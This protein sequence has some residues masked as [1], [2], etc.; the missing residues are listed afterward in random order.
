MRKPAIILILVLG[1]CTTTPS[2]TTSTAA[3]ATT[4]TP[5]TT[6]LPRATTDEMLER[7]GGEPCSDSDFTCV[8]I[9]VPL[10]HSQ[11]V[12]TTEVTFAVLA[13]RGERVGTLVMATGGPG[14]DG[15]TYADSYSSVLDEAI[16]ESF[17][18]VFYDQRGAGLSGGVDCPEASVAYYQT[19]ALTG[20]GFDTEAL[21]EAART[22]VEDCLAETRGAHLLPY[23][24]T[25]QVVGDIE[26]F[27]EMM[28]W[29]KL[30]I[31]GESYGTQVA[32][33]YAAAYP[34]RVER[35]VIDGVVDLTLEGH[36]FYRQWTVAGS[37]TLEATFAACGEDAICSSVLPDPGA[38]YDRLVGQLIEGPLEMDYPL[39]DGTTATRSLGLGGFELTVISQLYAEYDRML[40]LRALAAYETEGDPVPLMRLVDLT[41]GIDPIDES[42]IDPFGWSDALYYAV[43]CLDYQFPGATPD[44]KAAGFF[45]AAGDLWQIRL[46]SRAV[47][48]IACAYWPHPATETV[49]PPALI[50]EGIPV[51]VLGATADPATPYTQ[52]VDVHSRLAEGH[53]ITMEGG[54]HAIFGWGYE[55]PD[56]EVN[57]FLLDGTPPETHTCEGYVADE[58]VP[59]LADGGFGDADGLLYALGTEA[60]LLPEVWYSDL[61]ESVTV[62]CSTGGTVT[63]APVDEGYEVG[64]TACGLREGMVVEGT[65]VY[66]EF[67]DAVLGGQLGLGDCTLTNDG[68]VTESGPECE[69]LF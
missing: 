19:P 5:V 20:V 35:M 60:I 30:V 22:Y 42:V 28:G 10:D 61:A 21:T 43:T 69:P 41:L 3:P 52:G 15:T 44:E 14:T 8:T 68:V 66:D 13:A 29:E 26:L 23:L 50:A 18:I 64:Y 56:L 9:E 63:V 38:T 58:M 12:G 2:S 7:L 32:Q 51:L 65:I 25:T 67:L 31:W 59:L 53:I 40:L 37:E 16:F 36:E 55:C 48:D 49:R 39:P 45:E 17:D 33:T 27:R 4:L 54:P 46:G 34:T 24:A 47:G 62:G 6:S 1:A 57:A 11:D